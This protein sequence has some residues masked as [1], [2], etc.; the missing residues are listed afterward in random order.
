MKPNAPCR[1]LFTLI[2]ALALAPSHSAIAQVPGAKPAMGAIVLEAGFPD[3]PRIITVFS[4]GPVNA[5]E[6]IPGCSGNISEPPDLRLT[7]TAEPGPEAMPLFIHALSAGDTTLV[8]RAPDGSWHCNDDGINGMNPMVV[9]APPM[10]GNYEIWVGSFEPDR[11]HE[12]A[13]AFSELGPDLAPLQA[14]LAGDPGR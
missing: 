7:Y 11:N 3:D 13:L 12:V 14:V 6:A 4:G 5:A 2:F 9:F 8:V 1:Q 10:S